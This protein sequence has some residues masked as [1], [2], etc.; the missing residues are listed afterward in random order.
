MMQTRMPH[1][2]RVR[3]PRRWALLALAVPLS[4]LGACSIKVQDA[5]GRH[6]DHSLFATEMC[7]RE[8]ERSLGGQ[9]SIA[10]DLPDLSTKGD[11]QTVIQAFELTEKM[12]KTVTI[13][14]DGQ[15]KNA[16]ITVIPPS[17]AKAQR[18]SLRCVFVDGKLTEATPG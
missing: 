3:L 15:E 8:I 14:R 10:Y 13:E 2:A 11:V 18:R 1:G 9:S 17:T 12:F 4:T 16:A 7:K 5:G 6:A